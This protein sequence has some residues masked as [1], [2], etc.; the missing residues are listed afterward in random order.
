[1]MTPR[2]IRLAA[3][4]IG[5]DIKRLHDAGEHIA[6]E[7]LEVRAALHREMVSAV[8]QESSAKVLDASSLKTTNEVAAEQGCSPRTVRRRAALTGATKIHGRYIF[9]DEDT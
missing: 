9:A 2:T 1:M 3:Y 8:G 4:F 6:P 5:R 7:L